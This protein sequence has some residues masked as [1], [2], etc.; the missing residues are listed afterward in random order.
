M[1]ITKVNGKNYCPECNFVKDSVYG[2]EGCTKSTMRCAD[3]FMEDLMI[4][5]I[6]EQ[7]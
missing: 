1:R 2:F 6:V 7:Y 3:C 5:E 4:Y